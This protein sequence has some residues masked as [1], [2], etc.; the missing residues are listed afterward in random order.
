MPAK[1]KIRSAYNGLPSAERKVADFILNNPEKAPLMVISDIAA[2][3]GVSVPSV[4]RLAKKLGYEGF[5]DFRVALAAGSSE[6][7]D[8]LNSP[9]LLSDSDEIVIKKLFLSTIRSFEETLQVINTADLAELAERIHQANRVIICGVASSS[10]L[11]DDIANQFNFLGVDTVSL[12]DQ[13]LMEMYANRLT[14][15]DVFIGISRSGRSKMVIDALKTARSRQA[16]C[17]FI[18][19]YVNSI[20]S[21]FA[22]FFFCAARNEDILNITGRENNA[23]QAVIFSALHTLLAKKRQEYRHR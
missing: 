17:A 21:A 1:T 6:N 8:P 18:T 15:K 9:I 2:A 10:V 14:D 12:H 11:S 23:S 16:C 19:N 3:A 20:A 5:M 13:E 7:T 22:D 4:T